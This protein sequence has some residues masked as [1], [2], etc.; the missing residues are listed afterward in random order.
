MPKSAT[1]RKPKTAPKLTIVRPVVDYLD[2]KNEILAKVGDLSGFEIAANEVLLAIYLRPETYGGIIAMTD[3]NRQEDR[4]QGKASL[5]L[6][7]GHSCRFVRTDK[8]TGV[9]YGIPIEVGDWVVVKP[10]DAWNMDYSPSMNST[11]I[12]DCVPCRLVFDDQ[13]RAKITHPALVW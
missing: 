9:T 3:K 5:V 11:D 8:D 6:K 10:S 1:A 7:I 12:K 4:F 2:T 13:I